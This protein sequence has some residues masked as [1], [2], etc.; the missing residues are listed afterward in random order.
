M[1]LQDQEIDTVKVINAFHKTKDQLQKLKEKDVNEFS[2][3]KLLLN[4][5]AQNEN[6]NKLDS[7][8]I[9]AVD[10]EIENLS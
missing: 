4:R 7:L 1:T 5:I 6:E 9:V 8:T 3:I 2:S 10:K